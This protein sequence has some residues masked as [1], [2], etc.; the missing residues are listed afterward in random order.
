[1]MKSKSKLMLAI[2]VL[3]SCAAIAQTSPAVPKPQGATPAAAVEQAKNQQQAQQ[4]QPAQPGVSLNPIA[5]GAPPITTSAPHFMP[6][7]PGVSA[8]GTPIAY[9]SQAQ[10]VQSAVSSGS[11]PSGLPPLPTVTVGQVLQDGGLY[12]SPNQI[13]DMHRQVEDMGR[14]AAEDPAGLPPRPET[15]SVMVSLTPGSTPPVVRIYMNYPTS[16]VVVDSAGNPWPVDNWAGGS[17][18]IEIK[19]PTAKDSIEGASITMT[20]L[21]PTGKYTH[22]GMTLYLKGQ[23]IPV[24]LTYVGGQPVVDTRVELRVQARGPNTTVPSSM[25]VGPAANPSLLSLLDGVAPQGAKALKVIGDA[26]AWSIGNNR[27]LV[28]TP[29]TV[30]SPGYVS[31]MKSADGTNVYEMEQVS[32]L[33][34]LNAGQIVSISIDY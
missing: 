22:G 5:Y 9:G 34:A 15:S 3:G 2:A 29:L 16:L 21:T 11:A 14:A 18:S 1:M 4:T 31:G 30:V 7:Q 33:R 27:M 6:G 24:S 23:A 19:R 17:K 8:Y 25:G 32:E 26:Q 28:R 13:R 12:L 10:P 20:P